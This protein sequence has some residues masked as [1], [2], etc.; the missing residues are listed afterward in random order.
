MEPLAFVLVPGH[1][2]STVCFTHVDPEQGVSG[3]RIGRGLTSLHFDLKFLRPIWQCQPA[4]QTDMVPRQ[5][6]DDLE[7]R[8]NCGRKLRTSSARSVNNMKTAKCGES[9]TSHAIA[10]L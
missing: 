2:E 5:V 6:C 3:E 9:L 10:P 1:W 4:E 7:Q 8:L